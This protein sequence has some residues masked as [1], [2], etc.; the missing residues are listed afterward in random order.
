MHRERTT[1]VPNDRQKEPVEAGTLAT[2]IL[3][4]YEP[5][6]KKCCGNTAPLS[7]SSPL[8]VATRTRPMVSRLIYFHL[9][10]SDI[11]FETTDIINMGAP[12]SQHIKVNMIAVSR[13]PQEHRV[14]VPGPPGLQLT[15]PE[16]LNKAPIRPLYWHLGSSTDRVALDVMASL[17]ERS[18]R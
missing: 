4:P 12:Q 13:C 5:V 3:S 9:Q 10:F 2:P 16:P 8:L 1:V 11:E 7:A 17:A 6:A 14:P 18:P 15:Y